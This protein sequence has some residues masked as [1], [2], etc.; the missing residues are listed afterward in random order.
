M[1]GC[2]VLTFWFVSVCS[3]FLVPG[4]ADAVLN[5]DRPSAF[6]KRFSSDVTGDGP[7]AS[8]HFGEWVGGWFGE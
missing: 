2:W 5:P 3:V 6:G 8:Q 7:S 1:G 4:I